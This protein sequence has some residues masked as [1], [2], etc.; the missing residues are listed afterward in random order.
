[1]EQRWAN[2]EKTEAGSTPEAICCRWQRVIRPPGTAGGHRPWTY[3]WQRLLFMQRALGLEGRLPGTVRQEGASC[4][5]ENRGS[6]TARHFASKSVR[7]SPRTG[8]CNK[9]QTGFPAL[10]SRRKDL[11]HHHLNWQKKEQIFKTH[12]PK[13][14]A[15]RGSLPE[16]VTSAIGTAM[17]GYASPAV[18]QANIW[19]A[20]AGW[21]SRAEGLL[22]F[23]GIKL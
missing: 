23:N 9:P 1:M 14:S 18:L 6:N 8:P 10:N 2:K 21:Q 16:W 13:S 15:F 5:R 12:N 7:R 4:R 22:T 3:P 11:P 19:P 20:W 17:G